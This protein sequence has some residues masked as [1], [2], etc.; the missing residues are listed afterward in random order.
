MNKDG[1]I[2]EKYL[3]KLF[4]NKID[5]E[6]D[7][8]IPPD[9]SIGDLAIEVRR[10]N[11]NYLNDSKVEGLEELQF[12]IQNV[13]KKSLELF[14]SK[15]IDES[16]W[17]FILY[18]KE[19][20]YN[21]RHLF[22]QFNKTLQQFLDSDLPD[23]SKFKVNNFIEMGFLKAHK[24]YNKLFKNLGGTNFNTFGFVN[25]VIIENVSYCIS[26][27]SSKIL[28]YKNKYKSWWLILV[29]HLYANLKIEDNLEI[30]KYLSSTGEFEK[31]IVLDPSNLEVIF[32]LKA[33]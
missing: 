8:N 30:K 5:Y 14:N 16:Y 19:I 4:N 17:V 31:V 21:T 2:A 12:R 6:H 18:G 23:N 27:K 1:K 33:V 25:A 11:R 10:L 32:E 20:N 26:E 29:N 24:K 15:N 7:G 9:F 22:K 13:L 28:P 3:I